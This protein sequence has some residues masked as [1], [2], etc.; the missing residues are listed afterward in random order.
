MR[1]AIGIVESALGSAKAGLLVETWMTP[2]PEERCRFPKIG[3]FFRE[4]YKEYWQYI[5]VLLY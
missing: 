5:L 1:S 4:S 3:A 2:T